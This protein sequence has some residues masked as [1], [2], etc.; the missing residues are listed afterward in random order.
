MGG[1]GIKHL[2]ASLQGD[3]KKKKKC[4]STKT[5]NKMAFTEHRHVKMT[6]IEY[7]DTMLKMKTELCRV[8]CSDRSFTASIQMYR[9]MTCDTQAQAVD[10]L[11]LNHD[12]NNQYYPTDTRIALAAEKRSNSILLCHKRYKKCNEY[13][14]RFKVSLPATSVTR[15]TYSRNSQKPQAANLAKL[16]LTLV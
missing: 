8:C 16:R 9:M 11:S 5:E 7:R 6:F 10:L 15:C 3:D 1:R 13:D 14:H 4:P 2:Q 12:S